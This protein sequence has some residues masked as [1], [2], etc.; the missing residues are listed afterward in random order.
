[1]KKVFYILSA[2]LM[3]VISSCDD[4]LGTLPDNR[5]IIDTPKAAS[6]LLTSGYTQG[7]Y[8]FFLEPMTDNVTD[9]GVTLIP[10][11]DSGELRTN[12]YGFKWKTSTDDF[13]ET[14]NWYWTQAYGCIAAANHALEAI[15]E[16]ESKGMNCDP[17][18]GE[19]YL[20]RAYNHFMLVNVFA[21]HYNRATADQDLG[22]AYVTEPEDVI[23]GSYERTSVAEVY[24]KI[25]EDIEAGFDLINDA[26]YGDT[27]KYH[28]TKA[29]AAAFICRYY[30]YM[31]VWDKAEY[32]ANLALGANPTLRDWVEYN[33]ISINVRQQRYTSVVEPANLLLTSTVG[34]MRSYY[35]QAFYRYGYSIAIDKEMLGTNNMLGME[36]AYRTESY[37]V[38][39]ETK[40]FTK[41]EGYFKSQGLNANTGQFW[42]M[43]PLFTTDEVIT[44]RIEALAMQGKYSQACEDIKTF[45]KTKIKG[46]KE[47]TAVMNKVTPELVKN[48]YASYPDLEP[49][50]K[51][52]LDEDKMA[53]VKCAVDLR[54][55]DQLQEGSRWFD[56]KRFGIEVTHVDFN[57]GTKDI[58]KKND[59]RRAIQIPATA[60]EFGIT[61]NPR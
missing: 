49:F 29:A 53:F 22:I 58:L 21:Q 52:E 60:I 37:Q 20:I 51:G 14:P 6:E 27:P 3:L 9:R 38:S 34:M 23:F 46:F 56:I 17:Q 24:K 11:I 43:Q 30:L 40:T 18:K 2:A 12:E 1:M 45:F 44:N 25:G 55:H 35:D 47:S 36:W 10:G 16:M 13:Q 4:F 61:P 42:I 57:T 39:S 54:R 28:F 33:T 7:N 26:S 19:A 41:W 48:Y 15:A 8:I 31:G 5:T 50:Y 59:L 32:Y